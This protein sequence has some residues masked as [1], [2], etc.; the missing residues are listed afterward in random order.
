MLAGLFISNLIVGL[1]RMIAFILGCSGVH[2]DTSEDYNHV[3]VE[4]F[5]Y[6]CNNWADSVYPLFEVTTNRCDVSHVYCTIT[7]DDERYETILLEE[8]SDCLWEFQLYL[9]E[10]ACISITNVELAAKIE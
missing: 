2:S 3:I 6:V 5:D 10:E 8:T 9:I 7:F 1:Y 4:D